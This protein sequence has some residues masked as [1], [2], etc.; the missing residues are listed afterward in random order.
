MSESEELVDKAEEVLQM[1]FEED[2]NENFLFLE[3]RI[4]NDPEMLKAL[5][6]EMAKNPP[7]PHPDIFPFGF[8]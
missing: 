7:S 4:D 6:A 5:E 1:L 3:E 2:D 8:S